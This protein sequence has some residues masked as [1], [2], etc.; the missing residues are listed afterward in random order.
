MLWV[1]GLN[2][3][4]LQGT[5]LLQQL[6][7]LQHICR[8][9]LWERACIIILNTPPLTS[10]SCSII[11]VISLIIMI[12]WILC[13]LLK[14][15]LMMAKITHAGSTGNDR[16]LYGISYERTS[17]IKINRQNVIHRFMLTKLFDHTNFFMCLLAFH[18]LNLPK[19][20]VLQK[21]QSNEMQRHSIMDRI[22]RSKSH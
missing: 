6:L 20:I 8:E 14:I 22:E 12:S 9:C 3:Q 16:L 7:A 4:L 18:L 13:G 11:I 1:R 17:Y 15:S 21:V 19:A 2:C 5:L 10:F